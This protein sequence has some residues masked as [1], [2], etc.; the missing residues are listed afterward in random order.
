MHTEKVHVPSRHPTRIAVV[1]YP[2]LSEEHHQWIE[3]VRRRHDPQA[4]L[5]RAHFTMVFPCHADPDDALASLS[6]AGSS[7]IPIPFTIRRA[8]AVRNAV[9]AAASVFLIPDDRACAH[10]TTLH[11]RLY[12]GVLKRHL[13]QDIPYLPHITVAASSSLER[14]QALAGELSDRSVNISGTIDAID[15]LDLDATPV[16]T[17]HRIVLALAEAG[18]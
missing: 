7:C 15:L 4:G 2:A 11:D 9:G 6:A 12:Q 8:E 18:H 14:C 10:I 1:G 3:S 13:R 5:I 16:R 17:L